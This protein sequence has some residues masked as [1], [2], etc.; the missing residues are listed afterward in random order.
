MAIRLTDEEWLKTI[1]E[2]NSFED[3][4]KEF[5]SLKGINDKTFY[6][7]RKLLHQEIGNGE[8]GIRP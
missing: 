5:C 7:K 2:A 3:T 4:L 6:S 8:I 1:Y